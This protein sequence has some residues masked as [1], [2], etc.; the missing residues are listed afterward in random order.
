MAKAHTYMSQTQAQAQLPSNSYLSMDV[1]LM[2]GVSILASGLFWL[3]MSKRASLYQVSHIAYALAF[4][5]NH[6]HFLS[7]Y[8]LLYGDFRKRIFKFKRYIWAAVVVPSILLG[9]L[10]FAL[11]TSNANIMAH[12][13]TSMF[14]FVG[15]HYVKQ[16]FG[17][18]IVTSAQRKMFYTKGERRLM[19]F[20]LFT[21][22]VMSWLH[23]QV[24]VPGYTNSDSA[25]QFYG[26]NHYR[27][28]LPVW[29]SQLNYIVLGLSF[30]A[31]ALMH[32]RRYQKTGVKPS[33]PGVAAYLSL[34]V[35]YI[36]AAIHPAFGY[37]IPLFHSLQYL[38]FVY[39]L[40]RNQVAAEVRGIADTRERR[41]EWINRFGGFFANALVL[42]LLAFELIPSWLDKQGFLPPGLGTSP[43]LA[44]FL[45]F[46]NIHH[47]FI[48]NVI[49]RSDNPTVKEYLFHPSVSPV[50]GAKKSA[51]S[52]A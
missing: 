28:D 42:G 43:F 6:P 29:T 25:F 13:I 15:W 40:K 33:A 14:F 5:V 16:V 49:W 19:L 18:V 23:S 9:L 24:A 46:I 3:A 20:N 52:A 37:F 2:G 7:S 31:V 48:D 21:V 22:W 45:L 4:I 34:Y 10:A 1:M 36:P 17:C 8:V 51:T 44:S 27:L 32:L 35:W 39:T 38:A 26:L 12:I 11:V 41:K 30:V 47:Y 50:P